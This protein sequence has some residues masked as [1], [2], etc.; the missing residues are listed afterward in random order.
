[1]LS[2][3]LATGD[4][5]R[6][7]PEE[8]VARAKIDLGLQEKNGYPR[9]TLRALRADLGSD[10]VVAGSYVTLGDRKS[11]QVR[12]DLRLQETISGETLASIA[13]SGKQEEIFGLVA[14]A[15]QEM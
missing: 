15:G 2:T 14:R 11:G 4:K 6:I 10:Y 13:V 8:A 7:I 3:E 5:I 12:L 1:M 9:D